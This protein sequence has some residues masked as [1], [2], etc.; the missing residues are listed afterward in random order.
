MLQLKFGRQG[1][2]GKNF[3]MAFDLSFPTQALIHRF[4]AA[5]QLC[6]P[7]LIQALT[8]FLEPGDTFIDVGSH[9]GYYSMF[10]LQMVGTSGSVFAFEP[11]PQTYSVVMANALLNRVANFYAYNCAV[12]DVPGIATFNIN[13]Q[14]E[15]MSSLVFRD[16]QATQVSVHVTTLDFLAQVARFGP[17]RMLKIDVEGFEENVIR[18]AKNLISG[19]TVESIV[20]EINNNFAGIP[21]HRDQIIRKQLRDFGYKSYLIRP[22]MGEQ[23]WQQRCGQFNFLQVPEEATIDI[24]YGNIL[25]T[26]RNIAAAPW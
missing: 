6:D 21:K 25:S 4:L 2:D 1:A 15:G 10:A 14:D 19:G 7:P 18:G 16:P 12:G 23:F 3:V 24:P 9:I 5:G 17:V 26:K 8:G 20:F 11:N 22:W 13:V